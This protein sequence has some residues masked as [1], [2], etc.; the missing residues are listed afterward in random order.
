MKE[1]DFTDSG[2]VF[3]KPNVGQVT[4]L[5][6]DVPSALSGRATKAWSLKRDSRS[7]AGMPAGLDNHREWDA[8]G[9]RHAV[10][11]GGGDHEIDLIET[12]VYGR[13]TRVIERGWDARDR[14]SGSAGEA[15]A[16]EE[17]RDHVGCPY[18]RG[19]A[20]SGTVQR[21]DGWDGG[22]ENQIDRALAG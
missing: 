11:I 8:G 10:G 17:E 4:N 7:V 21:E 2:F 22:S 6:D 14:H 1:K 5:R 13:T 20:G 9:Q 12:E 18:D 3:S 15:Q 16:G 19:G